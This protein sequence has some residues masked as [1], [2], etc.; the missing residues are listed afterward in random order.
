MRAAGGGVDVAEDR[1]IVI[2]GHN[3][4]KGTRRDEGVYG[5]GGALQHG[6]VGG[7]LG[8]IVPVAL[9]R[10]AGE[11][12][13][14]RELGS[15]AELATSVDDPLERSAFVVAGVVA[16]KEHDMAAGPGGDVPGK[17][18]RA[19]QGAALDRALLGHVGDIA[20]GDMAVDDDHVVALVT[21]HP[22]VG[23]TTYQSL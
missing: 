9:R 22:E 8:V 6:D 12:E 19:G 14:G 5:L 15:E 20:D 21:Q 4:R 18:Q 1:A 13:A 16:N 17:V 10:L 2:V 11:R 3:C 7:E 23:A